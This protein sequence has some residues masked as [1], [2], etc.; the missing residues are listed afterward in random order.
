[1]RR[2]SAR[3]AHAVLKAKEDFYCP[4]HRAVI[5]E[6]EVDYHFSTLLTFSAFCAGPRFR[7]LARRPFVRD[8]YEEVIRLRHLCC[9][10][11]PE[12]WTA[13]LYASRFPERYDDELIREPKDFLRYLEHVIEE[14]VG[15]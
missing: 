10:L 13:V 7:A 3:V 14:E 2:N 12:T 4:E 5:R 9:L 11:E 1:M 15:S 8:L 6:N